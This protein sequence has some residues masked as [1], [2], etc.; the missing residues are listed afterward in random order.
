VNI[1]MNLPLFTGLSER[2]PAFVSSDSLSFSLSGF[3]ALST[4]TRDFQYQT[5]EREHTMKK[6]VHMLIK[7]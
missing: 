2:K 4:S 6:I 5:Y 3:V 7:L 1:C